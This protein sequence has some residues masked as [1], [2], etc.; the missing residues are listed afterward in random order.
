MGEFDGQRVTVMGLGRF[1]GGV[2]VARWL[3]ERGADVLVTD[4]EPPEKLGSS[5]ALIQDL[6][7]RGSVALRLGGH[8]VSDFTDRDLVIASP[9]VPKPWDNRF[10]RAAGAAG[11]PVTTEMGLLVERLPNRA[12]VI[13]VTGSA[14]KS[15]T[16]AMIHHILSDGAAPSVFGG[17]IGGSLLNSLGREI[18]AG[19]WVVLELSSFMLHWIG[20][21]TTFGPRL[22]VVTNCTSNH[23]D[24]HGTFEH[25]ERSKKQILTH[26]RPG[27]VAVLDASVGSW[28]VAPG[29]TGIV[30]PVAD[31]VSGLRIPGA[32]NQHNAAVAVRAATACDAGVDRDA[33]EEAVRG[34]AG[35][36]HRLQFVGNRAGVRCYNDSKATTPEATLLAI[37]AFADDPG[38]ARVHLIAGGYDKGSDLSPISRAAPTLAGLYTIGQTGAGMAAEAGAKGRY[39]GT[40]EKAVEAALGRTRP[41]DVLLMSPGCASWGQFEN[42]EARGKRFAELVG[43]VITAVGR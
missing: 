31:R 2:G 14:G 37:D 25:Y 29:V 15:T 32:H 4:L 9:A 28:N 34:F 24:W 13:A 33:A 18:T 27:D 3:V 1:G 17:N 39:Y 7:D 43:G 23:V 20:T 11:V 19:T 10:L 22:A 8:N 30:V 21:G 6:V 35:L 40:L 38:A 41:G 42:Y 16:A 26:Q 5:V 36:P 12:K